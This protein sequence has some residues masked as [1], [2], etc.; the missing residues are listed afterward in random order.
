LRSIQ[1]FGDLANFNPHVHVLAADGAF[2]PD[3]T[4]VPLP[5]VPEERLLEGF[6]RAVL[7]FLVRQEERQAPRFGGFSAHNQVRV[8]ARNADG[9]K[10]LAGYMLSNC[11][12]SYYAV[13]RAQSAWQARWRIGRLQRSRI[14]AVGGMMQL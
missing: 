12:H 13:C 14:V 7:E 11:V 2:L 5:P 6:R 4:F 1:T 9:R 3:G 8:A 10:T